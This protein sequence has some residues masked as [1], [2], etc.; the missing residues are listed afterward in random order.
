MNRRAF[1]RTFLGAA[2]AGFQLRSNPQTKASELGK[3][4]WNEWFKKTPTRF[5][6]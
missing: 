3:L 2:A 5:L 4:E 1:H 6:G